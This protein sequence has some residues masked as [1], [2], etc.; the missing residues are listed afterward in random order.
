MIDVLVIVMAVVVL[1]LVVASRRMK[2]HRK[3][4]GRADLLAVLAAVVDG[5]VTS[6][7]VLTGRYRGY[8]VQARLRMADPGLPDGTGDSRDNLVEIVELRLLGVTGAQP[9]SVWRSPALIGHEST[10][11]FARHD[12]GDFLPGFGRL[13]RLAGM[14]QADADLPDRLRAAGM[15]DAFDRVSPPMR[16]HLPRIRFMPDL[17]PAMLGR[18]H[19]AR[20]LPEAAMH[21]PADTGRWLELEVERMNDADPSPDRFAAILDAAVA[22]AEINARANPATTTA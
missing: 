6:E 19:A 22:I 3:R 14:P 20:N 12:G 17:R 21:G 7:Q 1:V 11:Q 8:D 10:W 15:F 4:S 16:D 2:A 9:W 5:S 13:A 18:L